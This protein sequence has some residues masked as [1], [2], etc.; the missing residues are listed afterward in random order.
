M[1]KF[2]PDPSKLRAVNTLDITRT[3]RNRYRDASRDEA[4]I[5]HRAALNAYANQQ[6]R[7]AQEYDPLEDDK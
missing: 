6:Y 5:R 7:Q 3:T 2:I 1:R 4:S